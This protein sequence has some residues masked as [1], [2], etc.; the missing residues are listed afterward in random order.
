MFDHFKLLFIEDG[1]EVEG[2]E[3]EVRGRKEY[4]TGETGRDKERQGEIGGRGREIYIL[5][6]Y[7]GEREKNNM[8]PVSSA[9][10]VWF[11]SVPLER[12]LLLLSFEKV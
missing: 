12:S 3:E 8:P 6:N 5:I 2:E 11:L 4:S 1:Y 10:V 9:N 7:A